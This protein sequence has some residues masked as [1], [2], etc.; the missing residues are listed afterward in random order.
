MHGGF[1]AC[2][3]KHS[4]WDPRHE[5]ATGFLNSGCG[6]IIGNYLID[7]HNPGPASHYPVLSRNTNGR[8]HRT[9]QRFRPP[10]SDSPGPIHKVREEICICTY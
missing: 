4:W 6:R 10:H 2:K 7:Q 9:E 1:L 5:S 8:V 3:A